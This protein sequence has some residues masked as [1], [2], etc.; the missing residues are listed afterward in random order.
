MSTLINIVKSIPFFKKLIRSINNQYARDDF[1]IAELKKLPADQLL[2]D[3]GCGSQRYRRYT[4]HLRYQ[5]QD[6]GQ[7][8]SD[9]KE[10]IGTSAREVS[11]N[12]PYGPIDYESNI[13]DIPAPSSTFHA[14]LC[15]EV[16]EH[17]PY[18]IE[19]VKNS[20]EY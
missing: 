7:Y 6:F 20:V 17:I 3:A 8:T 15:T 12:Y 11:G 9:L 5:A 4:G 2:L 10:T 18:P 14:I 19:T 16:F 13:W 1:V